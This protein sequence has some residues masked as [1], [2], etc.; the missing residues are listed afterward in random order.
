MGVCNL[1]RELKKD[2]GSFLSFSQYADDLTRF[3]VQHKDYKAIPSRFIACNLDCKDLDNKSIPTKLQNQ[4]ENACTFFKTTSKDFTPETTRDIFW[5]VFGDMLGEL[6]EEQRSTTNE[7]DYKYFDAIKYIGDIDIQSY[8]EKDG[9][10]YNEMYCYIPNDAHQMRYEVEYKD[11]ETTVEYPYEYVMGYDKTDEVPGMLSIEV[12]GARYSTDCKYQLYHLNQESESKSAEIIEHTTNARKFEF[13]TVVV[14]YNIV[15]KDAEDNVIVKYHDIPLGIFFTGTVEEGEMT[16]GITKYVQN[17]DIYGAGTSYGIRIC[18]RFTS[19]PNATQIG[20]IVV[21]SSNQ[22]AGF[23]QV[24]EAFGQSFSETKKLLSDFNTYTNDIKQH[25]AQFKNYR[26]NIPYI[27]RINDIPYWF[28]NGK[29]TGVSPV[30]T[31]SAEDRAVIEKNVIDNL[32]EY[33][34]QMVDN[35]LSSINTL[36]YDDMLDIFDDVEIKNS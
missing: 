25:L 10:G 11:I 21:E 35:R 23:A 26:T 17:D 20:E 34:Q 33:V 8:E 12:K 15:S 30:T 16:N 32:R 3:Y 22:Y 29:N 18:T 31:I 36:S 6:K 9:I 28:V 13:N 7:S 27:R 24:M 2:T 5:T 1:F 19:T 4:F 14:L